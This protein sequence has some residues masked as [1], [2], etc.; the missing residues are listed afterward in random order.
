MGAPALLTSKPSA[1]RLLRAASRAPK[2]AQENGQPLLQVLP[3]ITEKVA[4]VSDRLTLQ[5]YRPC[6]LSCSFVSIRGCFFLF[7]VTRHA[8]APSVACPLPAVRR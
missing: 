2:A 1:C 5:R 8:P 3:S 7:I 4:T 6:P